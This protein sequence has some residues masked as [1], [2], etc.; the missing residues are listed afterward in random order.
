M[1]EFSKRNFCTAWKSSALID[2]LL[3]LG[4]EGERE[5]EQGVHSSSFWNCGV[6]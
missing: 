1:P 6:A 4:A 5:L 3:P 2:K